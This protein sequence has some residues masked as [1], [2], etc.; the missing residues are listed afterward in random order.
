NRR[1]MVHVDDLCSLAL[2]AAESDRAAGQCYIAA[3][4]HPISTRALYEGLLRTMGRRVPGWA[5]PPAVLRM[6]GR[7]GDV[8]SGLLN[9]P[10]PIGSETVSRLLDSACYSG[11]KAMDELGWQPGHNLISSLPEMVDAWRKGG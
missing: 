4:A 1:S 2:L 7:M 6:A 8:A 10:L 9:R 5:V 11:Q 3:D